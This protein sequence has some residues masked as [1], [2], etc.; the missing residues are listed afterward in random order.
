MT[1]TTLIRA[2]IARLEDVERTESER[3]RK[4]RWDG[5]TKDADR[6]M[7]RVRQAAAAIESLRVVLHQLEPVQVSA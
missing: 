5:R 3:S 4:A 2:E 6:C 1:A 7:E